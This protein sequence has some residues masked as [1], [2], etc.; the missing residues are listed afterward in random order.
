MQPGCLWVF[1]H[2]YYL[3]LADDPQMTWNQCPGAM[4][5]WCAPCL[6]VTAIIASTEQV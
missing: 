3:P 4:V 2:D 6:G 5:V 1:E